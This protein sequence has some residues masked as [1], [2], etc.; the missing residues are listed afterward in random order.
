MNMRRPPP[1]FR[2]RVGWVVQLNKMSPE[3]WLSSLVKRFESHQECGHL[4]C[5]V[6]LVLNLI[7]VYWGYAICLISDPK[8]IKSPSPLLRN[9]FFF[10]MIPTTL[11]IVVINKSGS[12]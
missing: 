8:I 4:E 11:G 5:T 10:W 6:N 9:E 12:L 1:Q 2:F 7:N 3:F